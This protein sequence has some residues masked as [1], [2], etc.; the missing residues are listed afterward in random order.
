MVAFYDVLQ[1]N[2]WWQDMRVYVQ[3]LNGIAG[4]TIECPMQ[5]LRI[6]AGF[7]HSFQ[8]GTKRSFSRW[9][10]RR[11]GT[12]SFILTS[13]LF[14]GLDCWGF[15]SANSTGIPPAVS[16]LTILRAGTI[17]ACSGVLVPVASNYLV[18]SSP[19]VNGPWTTLVTVGTPNYTIVNQAIAPPTRVYY[20]VIAVS[21]PTQ[22]QGGLGRKTEL[23]SRGFAGDLILSVSSIIGLPRQ[24][25]VEI[26]FH[27]GA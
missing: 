9:R 23:D 3:V 7:S 8:A 18:Q 16:D 22:I 10:C 15:E 12:H 6:S 4:T 1:D 2:Y 20:Q 13:D 14:V 5:R 24:T 27:A 26:D 25:V 11:I 17:S 19:G 21:R